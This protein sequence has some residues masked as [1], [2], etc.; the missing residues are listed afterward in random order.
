MSRHLKMEI[1]PFAAG[2]IKRGGK[3]H[4]DDQQRRALGD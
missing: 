4:T 3:E 2:C 1:P